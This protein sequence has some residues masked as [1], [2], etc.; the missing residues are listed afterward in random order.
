MPPQAP[1]GGPT[2]FRDYIKQQAEKMDIPSDLA[3]AIVDTESGGTHQ[4]GQGLTT[5]K[6]GARGFFQL[7]PE[8]A[9]ELGVDPND[10]FQNIDG[11]LRYFKQQLDAH[12]GDVR[13]ALAAYNA[14]PKTTQQGSVPQIPET[15]DYVMRVLS[16]WQGG[17]AASPKTATPPP[18]AA[19]AGMTA[20]STAAGEAPQEASIAAKVG[21][22]AI[23]RFA[24]QAGRA[25]L[26]EPVQGVLGLARTATTE[27]PLAA[28]KQLAKGI[29]EPVTGGLERATKARE[30]GNPKEWVK[31]IVGAIP[32]YGPTLQQAGELAAEGDV[33]GAAGRLAGGIVPIK[34][35]GATARAALKVAPETRAAMANAV[36]QSAASSMTKLFTAASDGSEAAI[37]E[38]NKIV[39]LALDQSLL[40]VTR[41]K[42]ATAVR[43]SRERVGGKIGAEIK[44]PAGDTIVPTDPPIKAL[45]DLRDSVSNFAPIDD[46]GNPVGVAAAKPSNMLRAVEFNKRLVGQ[47]N[48]HIE[49]L[50]AHG[51]TVYLR[52][53]VK[54]RRDWD[55]FVYSSK[56]FLNR[57]DMAKQ[58][59]ARAKSSATDAIRGIIDQDPKLIT[60]A[61]LD[62]AYS[63]HSKLYSFIA[64][65]A[66]G[67][68]HGFPIYPGFGLQASITRRIFQKAVQSPTW[69]LMSIKGRLRLAEAM[70]SN[71]ETAVRNI[72]RPLL[73]GGVMAVGRPQDPND[74]ITNQQDKTLAGQ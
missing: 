49:I 38:I 74:L 48:E 43:E 33:A 57:D 50:K 37:R 24:G 28:G 15:Q 21:Q 53:L 45:E 59:E 61:D 18:A 5:S 14:G 63:A 40:R 3:L 9:K 67:K 46:R 60:L 51:P 16:A 23:R 36:K 29:V 72:L 58:Y 10:P 34:G 1:S 32:I 70:A 69:K 2:N 73:V 31:N 8:T 17:P 6:V 71:N 22:G 56:Q 11:G 4:G 47:I 55:D 27:G 64:D 26:L 39:P 62:K 20:P 66:F 12:K 19:M 7:M 44:G 30:E 25:A 52:D 68:G 41:G 54:L 35:V 13:L 65:E 42:W